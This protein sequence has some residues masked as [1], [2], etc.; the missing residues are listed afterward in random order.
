MIRKIKKAELSGYCL[1]FLYEHN[2]IEI[3]LNLH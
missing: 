2:Y 3:F 1:L